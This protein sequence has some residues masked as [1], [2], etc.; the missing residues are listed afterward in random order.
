MADDR[1]LEEH[2]KVMHFGWLLGNARE[3]KRI[4]MDEFS[5]LVEDAG[6]EFIAKTASINDAELEEKSWEIARLQSSLEIAQAERLDRPRIICLCGSSRFIETFAVLAW[7]FEKG[8]V[9]TL[10][11]HYLPPSYCQEHIPDHLA[12]HE[13]VAK[14]MDALHLKKI[15]L[16]DEVFVINVGGYIGEST[17]NEIAYAKKLGKHIKYLE[18]VDG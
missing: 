18:E 3:A 8:G 9:I 6:Q 16:A 1:L 13:D 10:G 5:W 11:L 17:S 7:E 12:E 4:S 14:R 2:Y 15:D